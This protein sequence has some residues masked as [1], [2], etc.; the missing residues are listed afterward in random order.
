MILVCGE[1]LIDA[2]DDTDGKQRLMP[3]GGPFNTARALARLGVPTV[4]MGRLSN[5]AFGRRLAAELMADGA[6]LAL[7]SYGPEPT[8]LAVAEL[9]GAG[10]A[11]YEFF[12]D[13]TSAPNLTPDMIPERLSPDITALHLG[14]LGLVLE[15]MASTLTELVGRDGADRLIMLDPNIRPALLSDVGGYRARLDGLMARSTIVKTSEDDLSWLY[16]RLGYQ[17]AADRIRDSGAGLV[18]VTLG[19]QGAYATGP[20]LRL[21][22]EAPET[23]VVDTIGAG[24]AFSAG[25][26]AWLYEKGRIGPNLSLDADELRAAL[27]FACLAASLTCAR[28]GAEPPTRAEMERARASAGSG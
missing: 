6:S 15:P 18:I 3:G 23:E 13:G 20:N 8:T 10:L 21:S 26:L 7:V 25:L 2:I 27:E 19:P 5:D 28:A 17:A 12:T 24:D 14:T 22:V 1:A 16:P 4:F 11:E 9:D